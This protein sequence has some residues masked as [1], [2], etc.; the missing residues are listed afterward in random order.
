MI[1]FGKN[2]GNLNMVKKV[3]NG[4]A[5]WVSDLNKLYER[6]NPKAESAKRKE[7]QL[8]MYKAA[9]QKKVQKNER[10]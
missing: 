10:S 4:D 9:M 1:S 3:K 7:L 6:T 8:Q 2:G 5:G